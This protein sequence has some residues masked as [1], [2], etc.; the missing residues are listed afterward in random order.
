[1]KNTKRHITLL[2]IMIV[3]FLISI[4]GAAIG[5]NMKGSLER[6]KAFKT[7]QAISQINDILLLEAEKNDIAMKDIPPQAE[8]LL[9]KSGLVKNTQALM[10]D[11]WGEKIRI[12]VNKKNNLRIVSQ[13]LRS[14]NRIHA[15]TKADAN[16]DSTSV[17]NNTQDQND[18]D[19]ESAN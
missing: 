7:E 10:K 2:E 8:Q 13:R 9:E 11:G 15:I 12:F 19:E 1:M 4:I 6:G 17:A 14:Y 3:I 16:S 18:D 5:Y